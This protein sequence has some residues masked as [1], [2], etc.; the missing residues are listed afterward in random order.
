MAQSSIDQYRK[1]SVGAASPLQLVIM[2]YDGALRFMEAGRH[3]MLRRDVYSQNDNITKAQRI[4]GELIATLDMDQGG[5]VAKNLV[6]LYTYVYEKL[7]EA[8]LEDKPELIQE[9]ATIVSELRESWVE[10]E[11]QSRNTAVVED[12]DHAA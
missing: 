3:A 7:V 12:Q 8:N 10:L 6:A 1:S 5:E 2:L 9:C 11:R 4:V